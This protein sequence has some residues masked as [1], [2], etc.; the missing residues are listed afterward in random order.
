VGDA[1]PGQDL[2][3]ITRTADGSFT[4]QMFPVRFV[5]LIADGPVGGLAG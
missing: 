2:L 3:C 5:P 1:V 4:E